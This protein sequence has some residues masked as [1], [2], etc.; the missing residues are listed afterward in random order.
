MHSPSMMGV[1]CTEQHWKSSSEDLSLSLHCIAAHQKQSSA[2]QAELVAVTHNWAW[3]LLSI[4]PEMY[5]PCQERSCGGLGLFPSPLMWGNA[6]DGVGVELWWSAE[7]E[8]VSV[9]HGSTAGCVQGSV[10][11]GFLACRQ[12]GLICTPWP[13]SCW[14]VKGSARSFKGREIKEVNNHVQK[15]CWFPLS[16]VETRGIVILET[17]VGS[18]LLPQWLTLCWLE[19]SHWTGTERLLHD[20]GAVADHPLMLVANCKFGWAL[21]LAGDLYISKHIYFLAQY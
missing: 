1:L 7:L 4:K 5:V 3:N 2:W 20:L 21:D 16:G 8:M 13:E 10:E 6:S 18:V 17:Q 9:A 11:Q 14:A 12:M 19:L 15:A